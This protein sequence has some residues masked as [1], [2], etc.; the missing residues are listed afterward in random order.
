MYLTENQ[1]HWYF[2]IRIP[3]DLAGFFPFPH[4]KKALKTKEA[5]EARSR[6][7]AILY[8]VEELFY[9]LRSPY[10]SLEN[11][12]SLCRDFMAGLGGKTSTS[13]TLPKTIVPSGMAEVIVMAPHTDTSGVFLSGAIASYIE[14]LS[15]S[16]RW[17][18][19]TKCEN[20]G[21][22]NIFYRFIG[23][24]NVKSITYEHFQKFRQALLRLPANI[25]KNPE[26]RGRSLGEIL[27]MEDVIPMS[28][29]NANKYLIQT[30]SLFRWA[31]RRGL[32]DRNPG[33]GLAIKKT[34]KPDEER[35][36]YTDENFQSIFRSPLYSE[37]GWNA[38][39]ERFWIP[40][41][42]MFTGM[43]LGEICQLYLSDIR[44]FDGILCIDVNDEKDKRLKNIASRRIVPVHPTLLEIG[45]ESYL[46]GMTAKN[47]ERAWPN[48]QHVRDGY[49]HS[50]SNWFQRFNREYIT[51]DP[52]RVFH[53]FRHNVANQLK[54]A[55]VA[56]AAISEILGHSV[57]SVSLGRY[58]KRFQ[59]DVL[60][61]AIR[62]IQYPAFPSDLHT[63][64]SVAVKVGEKVAL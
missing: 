26:Y 5:R 33:E 37:P 63:I 64:T 58:G 48:L 62:Q 30:S 31:L 56:S 32:V 9:F 6:M 49:G 54:Q 44:R 28:V 38:R 25:N 39:P 16:G 18:A 21:S 3:R 40:L 14:D 10:A 52:K 35:S 41:I 47:T 19:K 11:K 42:G 43:R 1:K 29:A 23:D 17:T 60:M 34:T 61:N 53:S 20:A 13:A 27:D 4:I 59:P 24:V 55:E 50:F 2:R 8:Q 36:V 45:L 7:A 15:S 22:L 12:Q 51:D 57:E 46:T